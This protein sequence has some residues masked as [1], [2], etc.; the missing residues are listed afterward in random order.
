MDNLRRLLGVR[1]MDRVPNARIRELCGVTNGV[2]ERI[3]ES[4]LR[5]LCHVERMEIDMITKRLYLGVCNGSRSVGWPRKSWIDTVR[6][7]LR[8]RGLDVKQGHRRVRG[9]SELGGL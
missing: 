1:R 7:C 3:D 9:R 4:L 6:D 5:W 8:K 2:D